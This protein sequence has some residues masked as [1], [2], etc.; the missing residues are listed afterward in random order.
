MS[1]DERNEKIG[2]TIVGLA[3][4]AF[5]AKFII[6]VSAIAL[7]ILYFL[8]KPLW[9]APVIGAG[10]FIIYR[11]IWGLFWRFIEWSTK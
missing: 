5:A 10:T 7:V 8:G 9:I 6:I 3:W 4:F 11:V 2:R 1:E